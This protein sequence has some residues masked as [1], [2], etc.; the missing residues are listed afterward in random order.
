MQ[1]A[2]SLAWKASNYSCCFLILQHKKF[3]LN[4]FVQNRNPKMS[5]KRKAKTS[6]QPKLC[7]TSS[8]EMAVG[9][10][11]TQASDKPKF[12]DRFHPYY[13]FVSSDETDKFTFKCKLCTSGE[14]TSK[15]SNPEVKEKPYFNHERDLAVTVI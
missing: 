10:L 7:Q 15:Q 13:E 3:E 12:P 9:T 4:C 14:S 1:N 2:S 5:Y 11:V 6:N 8:G